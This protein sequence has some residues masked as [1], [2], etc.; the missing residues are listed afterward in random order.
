MFSLSGLGIFDRALG[1]SFGAGKV[2][3][4]FSVIIFAL[5][6]VEIINKKMENLKTKS[7]M[8]PLL[9]S[10]GGYIMKIKNEDLQETVKNQ[11][12]STETTNLKK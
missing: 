1:F 8:Y 2:F 7:F 10:S 3:L 4:L 5:S 9:V 6:N 12:N 11:L